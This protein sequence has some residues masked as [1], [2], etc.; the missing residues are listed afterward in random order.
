MFLYFGSIS[1]NDGSGGLNG[2]RPFINLFQIGNIGHRNVMCK[3]LELDK[4]PK[5]INLKCK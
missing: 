3:E 1:S 4:N 2:I 5:K